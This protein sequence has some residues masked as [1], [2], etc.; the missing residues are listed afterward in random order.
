MFLL[1]LT[2]R[3]VYPWRL[4]TSLTRSSLHQNWS[5]I[6]SVHKLPHDKVVLLPS[7]HVLVAAIFA[8]A[9]AE[10]ETSQLL[11]PELFPDTWMAQNWRRDSPWL[12]CRAVLSYSNRRSHQGAISSHRQTGIW[13]YLNCVACTGHGVR[14]FMN[15]KM[16]H[17]WYLYTTITVTVVMLCSKYSSRLRLWASKWIMSSICIDIWSNPLPLILVAMP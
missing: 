6:S 8:P 9:R 1:I 2:R 17:W 5:T 11:Q 4:L 15:F 12:Y 13:I 14:S 7:G 16:A 3:A 10:M